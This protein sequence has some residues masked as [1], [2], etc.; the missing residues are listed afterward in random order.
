MNRRELE[1]GINEDEAIDAESRKLAVMLG[2]LPRVESPANFEF[3]VK[4]KIAA[5]VTREPRSYL[6][7]F[8][9]IAAPLSIVL[10]VATLVVFYGGYPD[11]GD[12]AV[13]DAAPTDS[14]PVETTSEVVQPERD[15]VSRGPQIDEPM[16]ESESPTLGAANTPQPRRNARRRQ[17]NGSAAQTPR[18]G[19]FVEALGEP[20]TIGP[21]G[22]QRRGVS[23]QNSDFST[24]A[25]VSVREVLQTIGI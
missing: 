25:E 14:R 17:Q 4:A 2:A 11:I 1:N 6:L 24:E 13:K 18:G 19:S 22:F 20:K 9:K 15:E 23:N 12:V 16:I 21:P 7:P 8:F 3:G 5:G 10:V